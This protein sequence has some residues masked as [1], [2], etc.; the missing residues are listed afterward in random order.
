MYSEFKDLDFLNA[1]VEDRK[2]KAQ[3]DLC[4]F[5]N[6]QINLRNETEIWIK[7]IK[8]C[9]NFSDT[10]F[11]NIKE[12]LIN[13]IELLFV[14][15]SDV[16]YEFINA[17][18]KRFEVSKKLFENYDEKLIKGYGQYSK[19]NNYLL[20]SLALCFTYRVSS[21]LQYLSTLLKSNDLILSR[22]K[23]SKLNE[24]QLK[25][26][27]IVINFELHEIDLLSQKNGIKINGI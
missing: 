18:L 4:N 14:R 3:L 8:F 27:S 26:I 25:I 9:R 16:N 11:I 2:K 23:K 20:F 17:L 12:K 19:I 10:N 13:F 22:L 5:R 15:E 7:S 6:K 21:N 1:Y 24:E